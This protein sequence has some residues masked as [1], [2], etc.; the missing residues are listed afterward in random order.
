MRSLIVAIIALTLPSR[1]H[2]G[3]VHVWGIGEID[4]A[5]LLAVATIEEVVKLQTPAT[6]LT[7]SRIPQQY[8][9]A[10]L[11]VHRTYS[12]PPI[13]IGERITIRY[14]SYVDPGAGG[15]NIPFLPRFEK[16]QTALFALTQQDSGLWTLVPNEGHNLTVP[17]LLS[18]P[19]RSEPAPNGRTFILTEL[20]NALAVGE[21]ANRYD[22]AVYLRNAGTWP[23]GLREIVERSVG[24]SDD[25]WLEVACALL[26]SLGIP[27]PTIAELMANPNVPGPINQGVAWALAKGATR[28]YPDRLIRCLL[29]N[30]PVYEWGAANELLEFKDSALVISSMKTLL[31]RDPAGSI[32]VARVLVRNGQRAFLSEA[33]D[34]AVKLVSDPEH[35]LMSRLQA[36]SLLL[37]D[38]GSDKQFDVIP[39]TLRRL[40][41][42]NENAYRNL[43][44]SVNYR[45]NRRELRL[46]SILI[47]DRR[48]GFGTLRYCD[49]AAASVQTLSGES[50][51]IKQEMTLEE[52]D[53]AVARAAAWLNS[54]PQAGKN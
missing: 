20:A 17:A 7:R 1:L 26:A 2:A 23:D 12:R 16:G 46:A 38:Y 24:T 44:A 15:G 29:R 6:G 31:S 42:Q 35:V 41:N 4:D 18:P 36:P 30:M 21:T 53:L 5:P 37:L 45:Q 47:D 33:L 43:F 39:A 28:D 32:Y 25:R 40:K 9:Q 52:R 48:P 14:L 49:V 10:L 19:R 51:G 50:F 11:R 54:H 8:W 22:A 34:A 27:H 13:P 3:F